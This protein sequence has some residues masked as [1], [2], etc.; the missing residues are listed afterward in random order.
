MVIWYDACITCLYAVRS[1]QPG[2]ERCCSSDMSHGFLKEAS[3]CRIE[4]SADICIHAPAATLRHAPLASRMQCIMGAATLAKAL[5][6][7]ADILL[8]DGFQQHRY[9][10]LD[11][12]VLK[13]RLPHRTLPPISLVAPDA[14]DRRGLVAPAAPA[15]VEVGEVLV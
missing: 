11:N 14:R 15:L 7:V 1:R 9:R 8:I 6:A 12:L 2:G 5:G 10:S 4:V 3:T 13:R